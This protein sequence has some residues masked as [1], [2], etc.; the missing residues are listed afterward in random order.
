MRPNKKYKTMEKEVK[1]RREKKDVIL[2]IK[3]SKELSD[4]LDEVAKRLEVT[5]ANWQ[6]KAWHMSYRI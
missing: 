5:K 6:E 3:M 2:S 1:V 4:N